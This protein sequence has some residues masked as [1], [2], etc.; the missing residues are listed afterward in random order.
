LRDALRDWFGVIH[1]REQLG[2]RTFARHLR[3]ARDEVLRQAGRDVPPTK[4]S[5]ILAKRFVTH[6][7]AYFTFVTTPG[8]EPT[9]NRAEQAIRFVVLDRH[10]TQGTRGE[11]GRQWSERIG[12]VLA[13]C[14]QQGRSIF[15]YSS[16][17][18]E[19][20]LANKPAPSLLPESP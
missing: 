9:N 15:A 16:V 13:S 14:S 17:A 12:T 11:G 20:W 7:D 4:H 5:Q 18:V 10:V 2:V 6:G 19:A 8:L 1:Q 3:A